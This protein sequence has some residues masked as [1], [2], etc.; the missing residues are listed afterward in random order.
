MSEQPRLGQL[1]VGEAERDAVHVAVVPVTAGIPLDPG[2]PV[3]IMADL[4]WPAPG[5]KNVESIGVVDPFLKAPVKKGERF[6]LFLYP[7]SAIGLRH[8]YRHPVLDAA[9]IRQETMEALNAPAVEYMRKCAK[10]IDMTY[11][12]LTEALSKYVDYGETTDVNMD[13]SNNSMDIE[14]PKLWA[15]WGVVTGSAMP[16]DPKEEPFNCKC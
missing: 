9:L 15:A 6:Y 4:A 16:K 3:G 8:V 5:T 7:G 10:L 1:I 11:S 14:W 2:T 12:D 13:Q